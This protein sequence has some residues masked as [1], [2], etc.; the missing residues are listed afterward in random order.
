MPRPSPKTQKPPTSPHDSLL[1]SP[2]AMRA[3]GPAGLALGT[4]PPGRFQLPPH[5]ALLN[6]LLL[7]VAGG[8]IKRV[9]VS[10]PPR[11]G[12]A[13]AIDTP[14]ATTDGWKQHGD[15]VPGDY[16]FAPDGRPI[17][18]LGVTPHHLDETMRVCFSDGSA[19]IA[20]ARHEW[21]LLVDRD[22][23]RVTCSKR[24]SRGHRHEERLETQAIFV[25]HHRR[26]PQIQV[27]KP[28]K[29]PETKLLIDPYVLGVWLG[30]GASRNA[31]IHSGK[32]D[33]SHFS[34]MGRSREARPGYFITLIDGLHK[35]LRTLNLL[36]NKHIPACYLAASICQRQSLLQGLMD[37]DGYI[38]PTGQAEFCSTSGRLADGVFELVISLGLKATMLSSRATLYGRDISPKYRV[39]FTPDSALPVFRLRRKRARQVRT[40]SQAR[41]RT[42]VSVEH[43]DPVPLNCICVDGGQYLAGRTLIATH[44]SELISHYFPAWSMLT[45]PDRRIILASYEASFA[46]TWGAKARNVAAEVGPS[47][48]LLLDHGAQAHWGWSGR[49]GTM[50][51][52]GVGGAITGRGANVLIADDLTKN[53]EEA[54]SQVASR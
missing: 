53:A 11:H 19:I 25:G 16:V 48:G 9:L 8:R 1:A 31:Y 12:K 44:N 49:Q 41:R 13:L 39:M 14:I 27:A 6:K 23:R 29:R 40:G 54:M 17:K 10:M 34:M 47:R 4:L 42:V 37:T 38:S 36:K 24:S 51:T 30:D 20:G 3:M 18:V 32:E 46:A 33:I 28:L 15:L 52:A 5:L 21:D 22:C 7:G 35:K 2:T 26:R 43:V 45:Y 50:T